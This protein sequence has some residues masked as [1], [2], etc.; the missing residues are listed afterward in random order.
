[1]I[2]ATFVFYRKFIFS[3]LFSSIVIGG[4]TGAFLDNLS[5][6]DS[7]GI[8]YLFLFPIFQY[9]YYHFEIKFGNE[10]YF[11]FN[12][13]LSRGKL[14]FSSFLYSLVISLLFFLL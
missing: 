1:M 12:L 11:Y 9:Y 14:W 10:Y 6:T 7:I 8:S 2:K 5:I 3:L 13:G 4:I